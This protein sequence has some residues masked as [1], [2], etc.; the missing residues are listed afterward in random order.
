MNFKAVVLSLLCL[1]PGYVAG[2]EEKYEFNHGP[3]VQ[4]LGNEGATLVFTTS[5][6][7]V[8]WV[9]VREKAAG[10]EAEGRKV[11]AVKDGLR[12]ADT[13][14][15]VIRLE[16]LKSGAEYQYRLCSRRIL[17]FDPYKVTFG[18]EIAS[19]WRDFRTFDPKSVKCSV[20]ALSDVHDS[21]KRL[22][23]LL[24]LG[25]YKTCDAYFYVGDIMSNCK[26]K[27]LPYENFIDKSTEMFAMSK[28][29]VYVR[30][31]HETRGPFARE[32]SRYIPKQDGKIY[33]TQQIG[34][35]FF[36]YLDCGEDKPSGHGEYWGLVDFDDYRTEQAEWLKKVVNSPEYKKAKYHIVMTHFPISELDEYNTKHGDL[37]HGMADISRKTLEIFNEAS[38]DLMIAGHTHR[39]VFH[40]PVKGKRNFPLLVGS[41]KSGAR[42]DIS[43]GKI[44]VHA[45][46]ADNKTLLE[47]ELPAGK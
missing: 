40:E 21:D 5:E 10:D 33:G 18:E 15:N 45:Y 17:K 35:A 38:V 8:S 14:F 1:M 24:K 16:G 9:E 7:G 37:S 26:A 25:D 31:N 27:N 2:A 28:P 29:F 6:K 34:D 32:F 47:K 3:Y 22:E 41:N 46:D 19:P 20:L 12:S 23:N 13:M 4:E 36:I 42:L 44:K 11:Y 39:F 30:G 43:D